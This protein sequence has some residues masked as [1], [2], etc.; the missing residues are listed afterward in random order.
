MIV[1]SLKTMVSVLTKGAVHTYQ[2][3]QSV[4]TESKKEKK[5]NN[6]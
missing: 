4:Q 3:D 5:E 2:K 1:K 6:D